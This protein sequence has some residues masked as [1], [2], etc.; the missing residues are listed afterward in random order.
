MY[1]YS[2]PHEMGLSAMRRATMDPLYAAEKQFFERLMADRTLRTLD[3]KGARLFYVP[4]FLLPMYPNTVYD[5]GVGHYHNL[6]NALTTRDSTF[7]DAW[8]TNRSRHVF[9]LSGDKGACL[10]PRGPIYMTHWGLTTPWKAMILPQLWRSDGLVS[11]RAHEPPCADERDVILPPIIA[12]LPITVKSGA[13]HTAAARILPWRCELFFAGAMTAEQKTARS[14]W[15]DDGRRGGVRCYSQG[16]RAAVFAHHRNRSSFCLATRLPSELYESSR[17]CLAPSGEGFGD[18]LATAML[19]GCVPLIIQPAV[20]QPYDDVLP[21]ERFSI[22]IGAD[23]IPD[24]HEVL[25]AVTDEQHAHLRA[26]VRHHA[27]AFEWARTGAQAYETAR[28]TLCL[29]AERPEGC[30]AL[31]PSWLHHHPRPNAKDAIKSADV[32]RVDESLVRVAG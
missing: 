24:L 10:W 19:S 29:R 31:R 12:H 20:R 21:Y 3:P 13:N 1:V 2:P 32:G 8:R 6:V 11:A 17:F 25:R 27:R 28:Y 9:F 18:R 30:A 15:C 7:A 26:G 23:R 22:R 4:T 14:S 16:V 5:K